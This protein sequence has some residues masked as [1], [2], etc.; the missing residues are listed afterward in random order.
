[1]QFNSVYLYSNKIDVFTEPAAAWTTERY[2]KVYNRNLKI[3]KSVDNR[4][5]IQVRNSD[6]KTMNITGSTLVFN[7]IARDTQNLVFQKDFIDQD[8]TT[9][10]VTVSLTES[11][12]FALDP[13]FYQYSIVKEV[14]ETIN[15]N[16]H[17]VVSKIP[18]Y[19][20]SQYGVLANLEILGDIE[21][22]VNP[23][24][25]INEFKL[26]DPTTSG[27]TSPPPYFLSTLIDANLNKA[28][29][30][31]LHTFQF[32]FNG[33]EGTVTVQGNLDTQGA[34]PRETTWSD[35][36]TFEPTED[37][38]YKNITGKYNWFRIKHEPE[39]STSTAKFVISQTILGYY[40]V[41]INESGLKYTVGETITFLGTN[42][43]GATPDNNLTITVT[44]AD[45]LGRITDISWTGT[46][47]N[48]VK[49]FVLSDTPISISAIDKIL[50]R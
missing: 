17:K 1:M 50:Y 29:A 28:T 3:Y 9:G 49:T 37:I 4:I 42:L 43:G 19:V 14:R 23:S 5:D 22:N 35:I 44:G 36:L 20:D 46:S 31:S 27:E 26:V 10:K 40:T 32:Y 25:V 47:Y 30:D 11:E 2:R 6:Q 18:L 24:R 48:G 38:V 45:P 13:G 33:Y 12:L 7:L 34:T 16:E 8:L 41:G 39:K 15:A 21:G